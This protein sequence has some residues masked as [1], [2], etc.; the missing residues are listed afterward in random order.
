MPSGVRGSLG[1]GL[2]SRGVTG[3]QPHPYL[4]VVGGREAKSQGSLGF[5]SV[6]T[7]VI[8]GGM[9]PRNM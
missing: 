4:G 2:N 3:P 6:N 1:L 5:P 9:Q 8:H 7:L